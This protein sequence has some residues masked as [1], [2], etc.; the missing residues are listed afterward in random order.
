[1]TTAGERRAAW[2]A[3]LTTATLATATLGCAAPTPALPPPPPPPAAALQRPVTITDDMV[4]HGVVSIRVT[5]QEYNFKTPWTRQAPWSHGAT[6]LVVDRH[7]ILAGGRFFHSGNLIEVQRFDGRR[8]AARV[9]VFD[10]DASLALLTV[11]EP[12]FWTGLRALPLLTAAPRSGRV[13][14][15]RRP[16]D[17]N[18][19]GAAATIQR[20]TTELIGPGWSGYPALDLIEGFKEPDTSDIVLAQGGVAGILTLPM[21]KRSLAASA[22]V[23][24]DFLEEADHAP[25]RGFGG[26]GVSTQT[27]T[28]PALRDHLGLKPSDG[29]VRIISLL[30]EGGG[31]EALKVG[32]VL[33]AIGADTIDSSGLVVRR[34]YGKIHFWSLFT[35]DGRRPGD[36]VECTVLRGGER[37]RVSVT[38]HRMRLQDQ[39]V[40]SFI[41]GGPPEYTVQG[42]FVFESLSGSYLS[43]WGKEWPQSAPMRLQ[44]AYDMERS[45]PTPGRRRV[46][47][48]T[49]VL[50]DP[51]NLGYERLRDV[52]VTSFNGVP[53]ETIDSVRAAFRRPSGGFHVIELQAGQ[54]VRRVVLDAT[55]TDAANARLQEM[56][57]P[58]LAGAPGP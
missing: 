30:P 26:L 17:G 12:S 22:P 43:T 40:P 48:L 16:N 57:G 11:D 35:L 5:G 25:Y 18:I 20:V 7:R 38:L 27:L 36:A 28:D 41:L 53:V 3:A 56:Y 58:A 33:V 10:P 6:G 34:E 2:A 42:G 29:G 15:V 31:A 49:Q 4:N 46:V 8:V 54:S 21:D 32:D 9:L 37:Q 14:V 24:R 44:I 52:I 47:V 19:E 45:W 23:L 51:A 13:A 50:P 1:M 55:Q 39:V